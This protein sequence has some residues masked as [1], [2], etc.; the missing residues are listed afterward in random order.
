M[1]KAEEIIQ[2]SRFELVRI[3]K[4]GGEGFI[5]MPTWKGTVVFSNGLGW[6][7]VSVRPLQKRI[8]PSWDDMCR[9]KEIFFE[10]D[11]WVVQ[12][13]PAKSEYVNNASNCL[14]LWRPQE[15]QLPTPP[16]IL[17]GI[18]ELGELI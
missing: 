6:D 18:K 17:V 11:E 7:H 13:H 8:V 5:Y 3:G 15:Q 16:D 12:Y 10:D 14:H 4:D 9:L 2:N 1:K